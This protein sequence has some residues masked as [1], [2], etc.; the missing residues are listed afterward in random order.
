M[1]AGAVGRRCA[2]AGACLLGVWGVRGVGRWF[3][4]MRGDQHVQGA[5]L[6]VCGDAGW[7]GNI[8]IDIDINVNVNVSVIITTT[9]TT[10]TTTTST[11]T[12]TNINI[13]M[14]IL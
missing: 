7:L 13:N 6:Q 3:G 9:T 12:S 4:W 11:T 10:T 1:V 8:D 14:H 2:G 5:L